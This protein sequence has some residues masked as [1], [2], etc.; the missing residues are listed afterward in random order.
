MTEDKTRHKR[1]LYLRRVYGLGLADYERILAEQGGGCGICGKTSEQ[2]KRNLAVDHDHDTQRIRGIL[3]AHCN[4]RL[5]GR[6]RLGLDS[7]RLL[8]AAADYLDREY[9]PFEAPPKKKKRR[10]RGSKSPTK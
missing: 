8:R 2:E 6:H 4:H 7:P 3:C 5:V 10:K 9:H 1:D